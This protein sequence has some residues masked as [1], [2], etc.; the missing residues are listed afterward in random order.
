[1]HTGV[2]SANVRDQRSNFVDIPVFGIKNI[3]L[4]ITI[5]EKCSSNPS[6]FTVLGPIFEIVDPGYLI[7]DPLAVLDSKT[8][9]SGGDDT[10]WH[11]L[12][13]SYT[14]TAD[15]QLIL[16]ARASD[17]SKIF[18]WMFSMD[19]ELPG[20]ASATATLDKI[21]GAEARGGSGTCAKFTPL[22]TTAYGYWNFYVP[23]EAATLFK[24][25][26]YHKIS[27]A[28]NGLLK[29]TIYDTDQ[30]TKLLTSEAVSLIDDAAYHL[31]TSTGVTPTSQGLCKIVVEI[32]DGSTTGYVYIDDIE[33]TI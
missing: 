18:Y 9:V 30:T 3:P 14:P 24:L 31:Y 22:S 16:R 15:R 2:A 6:T 27:T 29:V 17:P 4:K 10:N 8:A 13:L 33:T 21:T 1:M 19:R 32:Q 11:T 26:F 23:C 5:Y 25:N 20:M 28:W 7:E 12:A